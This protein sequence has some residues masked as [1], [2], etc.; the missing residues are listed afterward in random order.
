M[1]GLYRPQLTPTSTLSN[2]FEVNWNANCEPGL[3]AQHQCPTSLMLV[4]EWKQVP[5]AMFQ[6]LVESLLRRDVIAAKAGPTPY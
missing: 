6:H 3:I 2:T 5:A 4:A 1:T